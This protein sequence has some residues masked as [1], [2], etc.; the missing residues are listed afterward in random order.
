MTCL[1][2]GGLDAIVT[3]DGGQSPACAA[4]GHSRLLHR[5][6]PITDEG[7]A[8]VGLT[9]KPSGDG[10]RILSPVFANQRVDHLCQSIHW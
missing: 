1:L 2:T 9:D 8:F 4:C 10:T 5:S 7:V 6:S 3:S